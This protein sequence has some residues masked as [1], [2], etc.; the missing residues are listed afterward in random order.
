MH[1][2]N[3][4]TAPGSLRD[5]FTMDV[6]ANYRLPRNPLR[7]LYQYFYRQKASMILNMRLA[8]WAHQRSLRAGILRPVFSIAADV[9]IR[10]NRTLNGFEHAKTALVEAGVVFHHLSLVITEG[11]YVETGVHFYR[12]VTLGVKNGKSPH[13][14]ENAKICSH[15][16]VIGGVRVGRRAIVAPGAV[17][18]DDVPD[19]MVAAGVP[20]RIVGPAS[21]E[22]YD[23]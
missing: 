4:R 17:V 12:S 22:N 16:V 1:R 23:F 8:Q 20:A 18:I 6:S 3:H 13:I 15:S 14:C 7:A 2:E 5:A 10:R 9:F 21:D 19:G 11:A